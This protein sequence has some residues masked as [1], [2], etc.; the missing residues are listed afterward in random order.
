[1]LRFFVLSRRGRPTNAAHPICGR[2]RIRCHAQR[3]SRTW[4]RMRSLPTLAPPAIPPRGEWPPSDTPLPTRPPVKT[5]VPRATHQRT[6][7]QARPPFPTSCQ[8]LPFSPP[9]TNC[10]AD[11][12]PAYPTP[13]PTPPPRCPPGPHHRTRRPR[14][15]SLIASVVLVV[16]LAAAVVAPG[17][18]GGGRS[19]ANGG[20]CGSCGSGWGGRCLPRP[21]RCTPP[22]QG[23]L[24]QAISGKGNWYGRSRRSYNCV[25]LP[26]VPAGGQKGVAGAAAADG[27]S[28]A[29][30]AAAYKATIQ[31]VYEPLFGDPRAVSAMVI[32]GVAANGTF[33][34]NPVGRI[35]PLGMFTNLDE[36]LE[37]FYGIVSV[38]G[39][40]QV[41]LAITQFI[42]SL[43]YA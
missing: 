39:V 33:S 36:T 20:G 34:A 22:L 43:P 3:S 14:G 1:M 17:A 10:G 41:S 28:T 6:S 24:V 5:V 2:R 37:Y 32:S 7:T 9:A 11:L 42:A 23:C 30:V 25:T 26:A 40:K 31:R 4:R 15:R 19:A 18:A 21:G 13:S 16:A 29:T 35:R 38:Y 8:P 12:F 27:S